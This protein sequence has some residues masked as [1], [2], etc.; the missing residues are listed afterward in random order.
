MSRL[1]RENRAKPVAHPLPRA[2]FERLAGEAWQKAFVPAMSSAP[3]PH[4]DPDLVGITAAQRMHLHF[5]LGFFG[6]Q[7]A[8]RLIDLGWYPNVE[9][10][11]AGHEASDP[12]SA[13]VDRAGG[14]P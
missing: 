10:F 13:G 6:M 3:H 12:A 5:A 9:A 2:E 14:A 4:D 1:R 7:V 8:K 11:F